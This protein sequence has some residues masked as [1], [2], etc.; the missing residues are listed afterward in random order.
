MGGGNL[1]MMILVGNFRGVRDLRM[2]RG[3]IIVGR[4]RLGRGRGVGRGGGGVGIV[5][6]AILV[7]GFRVGRN[8][9]RKVK[10]RA[11][12]SNCFV[13]FVLF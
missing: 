3:V 2:R 7:V 5:I 8:L 10:V 12:L 13:L 6:E 1:V 11:F 4:G 9:I